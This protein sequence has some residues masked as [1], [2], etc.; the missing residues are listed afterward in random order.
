VLLGQTAI[1]ASEKRERDARR[2]AK[3]VKQEALR[4]AQQPSQEEI[5]KAAER[6]KAIK[7]ELGFV[8]GVTGFWHHADGRVWAD[9]FF[10]TADGIAAA[11]KVDG[12]GSD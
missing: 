4:A 12:N 6:L 11:A 8:R 1:D 7:I 5:L 9:A 3:V 2:R 10:K